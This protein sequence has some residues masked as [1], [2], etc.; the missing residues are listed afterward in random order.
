MNLQVAFVGQ[1]VSLVGMFGHTQV[2][3]SPLSAQ[4]VAPVA[5]PAVTMRCRRDL[6]KEKAIRNM[7]YA[8]QH[9]KKLPSRFNRRAQVQEEKNDD[10]EYL[11]SIYGTMQFDSAPPQQ[12]GNDRGDRRDRR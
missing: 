2:A 11:S 3:V 12:G 9:R 5:A 7:E 4:N 8:R 1:A 6:K 10:N